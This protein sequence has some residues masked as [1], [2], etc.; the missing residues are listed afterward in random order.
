MTAEQELKA[1][2]LLGE[3]ATEMPAQVDPKEAAKA[4]REAQKKIE[5]EAKALEAQRKAEQRPANLAPANIPSAPTAV[6]PVPPTKPKSTESKAVPETNALP[7]TE[8]QRKRL[9]T[10]LESYKQDQITPSQY[11]MERAKILAEP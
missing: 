4:R 6:A 5:A 2:Q 7:I 3:K 10:L 8:A 9:A 11:H 1:R